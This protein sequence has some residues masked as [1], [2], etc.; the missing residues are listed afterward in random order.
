MH[1]FKSEEEEH[2]FKLPVTCVVCKKALKFCEDC[3]TGGVIGKLHAN[4]GSI[5]DGTIYQI[6]ICDDCISTRK[7]TEIGDYMFPDHDAQIK[8]KIRK[9][10]A[11]RHS[12]QD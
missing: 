10:N 7:L 3:L 12:K 6:C 4:Y 9:N 2:P 8:R 11:R 1:K 5:H